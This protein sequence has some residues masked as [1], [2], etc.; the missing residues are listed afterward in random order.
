MGFD[1]I[2]LNLFDL[3]SLASQHEGALVG[4]LEDVTIVLIA[5]HVADAAP[6]P[7]VHGT[8]ILHKIAL[9]AL[10]PVGIALLGLVS[11]QVVEVKCLTATD[12]N[13]TTQF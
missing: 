12:G 8:L 7:Q 6:G 1:A 13:M 3:S 9:L 10:R 2:W 11:S 5:G 4:F